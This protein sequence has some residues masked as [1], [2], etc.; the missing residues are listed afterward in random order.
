VS[1]AVIV[2]L[3]TGACAVISQ[4]VISAKSTRELYSKLDKQ[5]E[6]ADERIK[7][8]LAINKTEMSE[9]RRQVEKHNSVVERTYSIEKELEVQKEQ[10]K[11]ANNRI[12]DLEVS[13]GK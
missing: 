3:I 9:L 8:E 1:D 2:A 10:I 11:V 12:K 13:T 5:S 4:I 6:I 7:S